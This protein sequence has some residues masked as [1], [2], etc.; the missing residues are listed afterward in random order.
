MTFASWWADKYRE[1]GEVPEQ[2]FNMMRDAYERGK[3]DEREA[4]ARV[5]DKRAESRQ[6]PPSHLTGWPKAS[7][8]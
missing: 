1:C 8:S 4:C 2:F 6:N 3:T 5:C 7:P